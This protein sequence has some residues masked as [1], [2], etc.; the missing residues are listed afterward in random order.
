MKKFAI[1][2]L[3]LLILGGA[4]FFAGWAQLTVPPGSWGVMRS[5][6]HG[7]D[8][9]LIR[10]GEF[11]WVWYKLIPAN[12][13]IL[14]FSPERVE[15]SVSVR[16]ELP[17]GQVY[18]AL[19]GLSA[20]FSWELRAD[21]SF[22]VKAA[23]LPAL[24]EGRNLAG[25]EDLRI[26]AGEL[27]GKVE[28]FIVRRLGVYAGA[29]LSPEELEFPGPPPSPA[30]L[31]REVLGEF[32]E[33]EGFEY[34][35]GSARFPDF[36]LYRSARGIYEDYQQRQREFLSADLNGAAELRLKSRLR[37]DELEKYGELLTKYPILLQY[38]SLEAE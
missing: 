28:D 2:V 38:L 16:G 15:R 26:F 37:F 23:A 6:T 3:L 33:L 35:I 13:E 24:V 9:D 30:D 34:R 14:V 4:G 5:K 19:A 11:R 12:V 31:E 36:A 8:R 10:A 1:T 20:D 32:P 29:G 27:G 25:Q 17:S 18:A 22:T 21:F 7:L